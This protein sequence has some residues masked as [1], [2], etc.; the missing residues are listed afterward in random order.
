MSRNSWSPEIQSLFEQTRKQFF[1]LYTDDRTVSAPNLFDLFGK[2]PQMWKDTTEMI[3][4]P[5][6]NTPQDIRNYFLTAIFNPVQKLQADRL[7]K[8]KILAYAYVEAQSDQYPGLSLQPQKIANA[9]IS[10]YLRNWLRRCKQETQTIYAFSKEPFETQAAPRMDDNLLRN[11][12]RYAEPLNKLHHARKEQAEEEETAIL[13]APYII[14]QTAHYSFVDL[15]YLEYLRD[16]PD[17]L[18]KMLFFR[19]KPLG[20]PKHSISRENLAAAC[21]ELVRFIQTTDEL[22]KSLSPDSKI[23]DC[24]RYVDFCM[25]ITE[26]EEATRVLL[27][28]KIL[29]EAAERNISID[30][31][32]RKWFYSIWGRWKWPDSHDDQVSSNILLLDYDSDVNLFLSGLD[33]QLFPESLRELARDKMKRIRWIVDMTKNILVTALPFDSGA[34]GK[35]GSDSGWTDDDYWEAA[36]FFQKEYPISNYFRDMEFP[37]FPDPQEPPLSSKDF[38]NSLR[39]CY[40]KLLEFRQPDLK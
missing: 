37:T 16:Y 33:P 8:L 22:G 23:T 38:Y 31:F 5:N 7:T 18:T 12:E 9:A 26:Y 15:C 24:K 13:E 3:K 19:T 35:Q 27:F 6:P 4:D 40:L 28:R 29:L 32:N 21:N 10:E 2:N 36:A 17:N 14:N 25:F 34:S 30:S 11:T 39:T 20:D 1:V